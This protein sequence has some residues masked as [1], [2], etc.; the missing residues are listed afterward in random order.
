MVQKQ[1]MV[2]ELA[3][4]KGNKQHKRNLK[5]ENRFGILIIRKFE[6]K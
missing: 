2:Y 3:M 5:P 6:C 1:A 4:S